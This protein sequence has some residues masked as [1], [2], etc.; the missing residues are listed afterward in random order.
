MKQTTAPEQYSNFNLILNIFKEVLIENNEAKLADKIPWINANVNNIDESVVTKFLHINSISFQLLNIYETI[1]AAKKRRNLQ[2]NNPDDI[3]FGKWNHVFSEYRKKG[4]SEKTIV[5]RLKQVKFEPV[6][7]AHPTESKR[8]VVLRLYREIYSLIEH[9]EYSE[10]NTTYNDELK[11]E[12]KQTLNKLYFIEEFNIEKPTVESELENIV[13][14]F[15]DIFPK[16]IPVLDL[17]L[18]RAWDNA[19]FDPS[20]LNDVNNLPKIT[21]GNWVGGDRDGHP[22]VTAETTKHTLRTFRLSGLKSVYDLL[23][24]LADQ[25]SIYTIGHDLQTDFFE[26]FIQ[27]NDEVGNSNNLESDQKFKCFIELLV[28]KLPFHSDNTGKFDLYKNDNTYKTAYTLNKDLELVKLALNKFGA[29]S[30]ANQEVNTVIRHIQIFGF[31]FARVDIRQ[32]SEYHEHV[33]LNM[34]KSTAKLDYNNLK[35]NRQAFENFILDELDKNS[36]FIELF[37]KFDDKTTEIHNLYKVLKAYTDEYGFTGIGSIIISMT[38]NVFDLFTV[39]LLLRESG[40]SIQT[41]DGFALPFSVVPLFETIDDLNNS[42]EILDAYLSHPVVK[43]NILLHQKTYKLDYPVQEVMVGYSDSN[44]D[45]GIISSA[46]NLYKAQKELIK[47]GQKHGVIIKFF[48]GKGGTISRGAGP[49]QYFLDSLPKGSLSGQIRSTEQGETIEKKFANKEN[50]AFNLELFLAGSLLHSK[51]KGDYTVKDTD[52]DLIQIFDFLSQESEKTFRRLIKN[53][54]FIHFYN[55]AT[56][57]DAIELCKIGSRPARRT[58]QRTLADLRA[59]PWVFSWTQ[60]RFFI[61]GWYGVGSG[62]SKLKASR[63]KLYAKLKELVHT[64]SFVSYVLTNIDTSIA[65]SNKDVL[66]MYSDLVTNTKTKENIQGLI[67]NEFDKTNKEMLDLLGL[68]LKDRRESFHNSLTLRNKALELLHIE[69]L[70]L[71][72]KWR[73]TNESATAEE[74]ELMLKQLQ[75]SI[76]AISSALGATG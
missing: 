35:K 63:P 19:G 54:D 50:T 21:F 34:I 76:N 47:L 52:A 40:L 27:V 29:N 8:P 61:S 67:V 74:R 2:L 68:P 31:Y 69:Q 9:L 37:A 64:N 3:K 23:L 71:L 65:T 1:I 26:R 11:T 14:Y 4:Y 24:N 66:T 59:I 41:D 38:R 6:L 25:L 12:I 45:G 46:W 72:K 15:K 44:K 36:Q 73:K 53:S 56:P 16:S 39:I 22:F 51:L 20:Y 13:S 30:L 18:K 48:H 60:S 28:K 10:P 42:Y 62:L 5:D 55:E 17:K 33:F 49:T 75:L 7:T 43:R 70:K 58:A 32:N 57:I